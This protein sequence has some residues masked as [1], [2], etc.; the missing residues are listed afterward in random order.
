MKIFVSLFYLIYIVYSCEPVK[1][2]EKEVVSV[3]YESNKIVNHLS[4][5]Y[6]I[7]D[8]RFK[9][10]GRYSLMMS[11]NEIFSI[12]K[13]ILDDKFYKLN[14]S[15][16]FVKSCK[17]GCKSI[18]E[19]QYKSGR[20]QYFVFDNYNYKNNFNNWDYKKIVNLEEYIAKLMMSKKFDPDPIN[21]KFQVII[22]PDQ[23]S[24]WASV[25][26]GALAG[27]GSGGITSIINGQNFFEGLLKG[28]VIEG[29][30]AGISYTINYF[31]KGY[32]KPQY[33]TTDDVNADAGVS[34]TDSKT[35]NEN[36]IRARSKV[37]AQITK[38]AKINTEGVGVSTSDGY[39]IGDN[40]KANV[41]GKTTPNFRTGRSD[42]LYSTKAA[43]NYSIL[44]SLSL[45]H[46]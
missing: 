37:D 39:M 24:F 18:I 13:K 7:L 40:G 28:A 1:N 17:T 32:D 3:T 14:D 16:N 2:Q 44:G 23:I 4:E 27:A 43:S 12:K 29:A 9:H 11:K 34:S 22:N 42:I 46:L 26:N 41:L 20:K 21:V 10:P 6:Y 38:N 30:I 33:T 45:N 36:I 25:G 19:I 15:L 35:M 5:N 31:A 8:S